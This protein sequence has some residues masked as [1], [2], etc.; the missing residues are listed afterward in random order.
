MVLGDAMKRAIFIAV[1]A[2]VFAAIGFVV[3]SFAT[4]WYSDHFAKSD[5]DINV[6]VGVFL[7]LWPLFAG[8]GAYLGNKLCGSAFQVTRPK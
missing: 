3:G 6:S 2:L 8:L 5:D 1:G 7:V 4:N